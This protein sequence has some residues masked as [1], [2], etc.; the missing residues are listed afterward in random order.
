MLANPD[1][2][3]QQAN[4][5]AT[6]YQRASE[7]SIHVEVS[8]LASAGILAAVRGRPIQYGIIDELRKVGG[9]TGVIDKRQFQ[10]PESH[11][12]G[13]EPEYVVRLALKRCGVIMLD[14]LPPRLRKVILLR[15]WHCLKQAEV[16][17]IMG[18]AVT[19]DGL[20]CGRVSQLER[21]AC[22]IIK[23]ELEK[24]GIK[25]LRHVI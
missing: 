20:T 15:Y 3:I 1:K 2:I 6:V 10:I 12:H 19:N 9:R 23:T 7:S 8:D 5:I 11:D 17:V 24:R 16:G 13:V 22:Q 18:F 14:C 4:S 25:S 21:Q